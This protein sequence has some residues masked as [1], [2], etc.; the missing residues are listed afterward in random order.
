MENLKRQFLFIRRLDTDSLKLIAVITMLIDH[1]AESLL[2]QMIPPIGEKNYDRWYDIY[3]MLRNI[4]RTAF[5]IFAFLLV[6]GFFHTHSRKKYFRRLILFALLSEIPYNMAFHGRL[7][8]GMDQNVFWTLS[9][10][11]LVIL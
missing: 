2:W 1:I 8:Y 11:F 7:F 5:P 4:G 6:E 3:H 9:M 10:G